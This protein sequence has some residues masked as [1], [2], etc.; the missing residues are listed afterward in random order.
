M[1]NKKETQKP[2]SCK[3][4]RNE[5]ENQNDHTKEAQPKMALSFC[6]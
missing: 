3:V 6:S 4:L 2:G 1:I 5:S